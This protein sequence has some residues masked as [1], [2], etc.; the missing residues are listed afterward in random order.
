LDK[1][2][3]LMNSFSSVQ[4]SRSV[5]SDSLLPHESQHT[6]PPCPSPTPGVHSN[7]RP[8]SQWCHRAISSGVCCLYFPPRIIKLVLGCCWSVAQSNLILCNCMDRSARLPCPS[9]SP[10]ACSNLCPLSPWC[11]PTIS[12]SFITFSSCLPSS[13]ASGSFLMSRFF[14]SGGQSSRASASASILPMN[15]QDLFPLGLIAWISFQSKGLSRI[16]SNTIVQKHQFFGAQPSLWSNSQIHTWL[17][18]KP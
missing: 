8:L 3:A 17:L 9:P 4:F 10:R 14:A 16:F 6:R 11:H 7:S 18:E 12:P 13:P 2:I 1:W 15:I 5:M